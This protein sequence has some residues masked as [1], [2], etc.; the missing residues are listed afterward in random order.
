MSSPPYP[1]VEPPNTDIVFPDVAEADDDGVLVVGE[2]F[3]A[4]TL[5]SAYRRGIFP[6]PHRNRGKHIVLWCSPDPRTSYSLSGE[7]H[8]SRSLKRTLRQGLFTVTLNQAFDDVIRLC[9]ETRPEGTWIIPPLSAG[10]QTLHR[11]GFAHSVEVWQGEGE[12]R[13]LVGGIYGVAVGKAFAGESMFHLKTDAS[14]VAFFALAR[15]LKASGFL[16]FDAQVMNPHLSSLGCIEIPR[17]AY[18]A[19]LSAA[20]PNG[21]SPRLLLSQ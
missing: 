5:L 9:G 21:L 20:D 15:A 19:Q 8:L 13:V 1:P 14:K 12:A 3:R 6:W 18:L 17:S 4:G 11:L 7:F 10:Y 2:D 16:I